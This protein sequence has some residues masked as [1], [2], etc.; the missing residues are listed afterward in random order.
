MNN[1]QIHN[2]TMTS[3]QLAKILPYEKKEINKKIRSLFGEAKAREMFSPSVD[4]QNRVLEY[5]LPKKESIMLVAKHDINYL[6][7]I[8]EFWIKGEEGSLQHQLPQTFAEAMQLAADQ[9]KTIEAKDKLLIASN[10]AS[11]KAG[12][13]LVREFCKSINIVDIGEKR[14]FTWMREQKILMS[15]NEP[16]QQYVARGLL[17]WKPTSEMHGGKFRYSLRITPRGKIWLSAKYLEFLDGE[18]FGK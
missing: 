8:T 6:E 16:Y 15:S 2:E 1:L 5:N 11:I 4:P 7:A 12:E 17:I 13:I 9:A 10:E 18:D 14:M 3:S